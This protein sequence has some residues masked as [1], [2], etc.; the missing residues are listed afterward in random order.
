MIYIIMTTVRGVWGEG[1]GREFCFL[2]GL[3]KGFEIFLLESYV[4]FLYGT[5]FDFVGQSVSP[6]YFD[7]ETY[8]IRWNTMPHRSL[9]CIRKGTLLRR[10]STADQWS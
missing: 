1:K 6:D 7:P 2:E 5:C 9:C 4:I 8:G 3:L 10:L